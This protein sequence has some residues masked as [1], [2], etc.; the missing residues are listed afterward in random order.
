MIIKGL[1]CG[2]CLKYTATVNVGDGVSSGLSN[3]Q[4]LV[5]RRGMKAERDAEVVRRLRQAGEA[6][7]RFFVGNSAVQALHFYH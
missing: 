7:Y 5:R 4:G 1:L 3:T 6:S 2:N